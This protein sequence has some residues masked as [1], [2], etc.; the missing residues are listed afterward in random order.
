MYTIK[1]T[2]IFKQWLRT[3]KDPIARIMITKRIERVKQGNLGDYK[4]L[5]GGVSELRI[6]SG[7][8]YRI[9]YTQI[10]TTIYFLLNGGDKS[11]QQTDIVKARGLLN[12][13]KKYR[14][15]HD[16]SFST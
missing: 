13:M 3:L 16:E 9:Y 11:S 1:Q 2:D 5:G 12:E 6:N 15:E 14:G 8:G 10:D 7:K 4:M